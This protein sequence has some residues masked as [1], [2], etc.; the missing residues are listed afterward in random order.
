MTCCRQSKLPPPPPTAP[1]QK[2]LAN[3]NSQTINAEPS[4]R[5]SKLQQLA[6]HI[7]PDPLP[8]YHGRRSCQIGAEGLTSF[9]NC[10]LKRSHQL[11]LHHAYS[12]HK[13]MSPNTKARITQGPYTVNP[14][15]SSWYL[16][17]RPSTSTVKSTSS[18][19]T[20]QINSRSSE[21]RKLLMCQACALLKAKKSSGKA[22]LPSDQHISG[23]P[24][25]P[26]PGAWDELIQKPKKVGV[27]GA[28]NVETLATDYA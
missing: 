24:I 15:R 9:I 10:F 5:H 17:P 7:F 18:A 6:N 4:L 3:W 14:Y 26:R 25:G 12:P 8:G 28:V 16:V 13:K 20:V 11:H 21:S 23:E 22:Q 1:K 27:C 19:Q 2:R